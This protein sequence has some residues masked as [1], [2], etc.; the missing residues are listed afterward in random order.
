VD[1][2]PTAPS[3]R[4]LW[5]VVAL[6][7]LVAL[8]TGVLLGQQPAAYTSSATVSLEPRSTDNVPAAST[9]SLLT[10][11][12]AAYAAADSTLARVAE[13]AGLD[14]TDV[15]Q[16]VVVTLEAASTNVEIDVTLADGADAVA[17][18]G[19]VAAEVVSFGTGDT[20]LRAAIAVPPSAPEQTLV[21]RAEPVLAPA[22]LGLGVALLALG[23]FMLL[24]PVLRR[25]RPAE[26]TGPTETAEPGVTSRHEPAAPGEPGAAGRPVEDQG[27]VGQGAD[28]R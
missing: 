7:G 13:E 27:R 11:P 26:P 5:L 10:A 2:A 28:I 22:G 24:A 12:Y 17:V 15:R 21:S 25:R 14:Y 8:T 19:R 6:V 9:I 3:R 20:T 4:G 18:A 1:D 16:G 23:V